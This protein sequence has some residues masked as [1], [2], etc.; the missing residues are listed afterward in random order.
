MKRIFNIEFGQHL[1]NDFR[2]TLKL[3][4]TST[5]RQPNCAYQWKTYSQNMK[6]ILKNG[7]HLRVKQIKRTTVQNPKYGEISKTTKLLEITTI[8]AMN[9]PKSKPMGNINGTQ[10]QTQLELT[11][12]TQNACHMVHL[13]LLGKS[14]AVL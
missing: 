11:L 9:K 3:K 13:N 10:L 7:Q 4:N 14:H 12:Y 8:M 1:S 6:S 2:Y 5:K